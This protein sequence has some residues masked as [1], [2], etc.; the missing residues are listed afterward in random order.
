MPGSTRKASRLADLCEAHIDQYSRR[1]YQPRSDCRSKPHRHEAPALLQLLR[2]LQARGLCVAPATRTLPVDEL[3]A[4]FEQFLLRD[5][6]LAV[7]TV[8]GYRVSVR[9]FLIDRFASGRIDFGALRA[10]DIINFVQR[11]PRSPRP[12]ALKHVVTALRAF[13]RWGQYRGEARRAAD[14]RG[15]NGGIVEYDA[16]AA[17]SH[18]GRARTPRDR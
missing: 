10:R 17:Q 3:L 8:S 16:T 7:G 11:Q 12:H 2:Y 18:I 9:E 4:D 13:L 5:R 15:A 6:G 1:Q 14:Q